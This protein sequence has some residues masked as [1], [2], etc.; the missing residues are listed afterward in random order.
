MEVWKDVV[1]LYLIQRL[2]G[3]GLYVRLYYYYLCNSSVCMRNLDGRAKRLTQMIKYGGMRWCMKHVCMSK[4]QGSSIRSSSG[5][6]KGR[7]FGNKGAGRGYSKGVTDKNM[8]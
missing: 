4:M 1:K 8:H 7:K 3:L 6:T 2:L 5:R